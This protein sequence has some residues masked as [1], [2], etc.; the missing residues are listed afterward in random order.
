LETAHQQILNEKQ[1]MVDEVKASQQQIT[2]VHTLSRE[3]LKS[4][5]YWKSQAQQFQQQLTT[6]QNQKSTPATTNAINTTKTSTGTSAV[7]AAPR[8]GALPPT[9]AN[10]ASYTKQGDMKNF[11]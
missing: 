7:V 8:A 1:Q 3:L 10:M 6:Q 9:R 5:E 11:F 2:S 4:A